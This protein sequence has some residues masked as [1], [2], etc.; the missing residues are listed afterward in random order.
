MAMAYAKNQYGI[1]RYRRIRNCKASPMT[2]SADLGSA[3]ADV[4]VGLEIVRGGLASGGGQELD[5]PE[6]NRDLFGNLDAHRLAE[7]SG[8]ATGSRRRFPARASAGTAGAAGDKRPDQAALAP[9][10]PTR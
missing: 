7:R 4:P 2:N 5:H 3:A 8:S 6:Q 1:A 10:S 9:A